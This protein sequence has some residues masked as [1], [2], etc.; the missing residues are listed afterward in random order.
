MWQYTALT[1][2]SPNFEPVHCSM[3][4]PNCR[5]LT[6]IQIFQELGN[7]VWYSHLFKNFPEFVV[8]YTVKDFSIINE[9]EVDVS[10]EFPCL[11]C[12]PA[13]V[14]NFISGFSAFSKSSSPGLVI[15][16][17]IYSLLLPSLFHGFI[18]HIHWIVLSKTL[19]CVW[20]TGCTSWGVK[21]IRE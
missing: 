20:R 4:G 9:T 1:Y 7:V 12:D 6:C 13:D 19:N 11:F 15:F 8:I 14:D 5:F 18:E 21:E 3:S 16:T 2:S 10:L 17:K